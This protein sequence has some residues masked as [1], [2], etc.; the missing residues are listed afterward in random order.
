MMRIII[1]IKCAEL[2]KCLRM[3]KFYSL[4][5][6]SLVKSVTFGFP[7]KSGGLVDGCFCTV[8]FFGF[9][10]EKKLLKLIHFKLFF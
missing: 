7:S 6:L 1:I 10:G 8:M 9:W 2:F 5:F 4:I 3:M